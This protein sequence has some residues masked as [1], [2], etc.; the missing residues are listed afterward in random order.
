ELYHLHLKSCIHFSNQLDT[1]LINDN[2]ISSEELEMISLFKDWYDFILLLE[3]LK[4]PYKGKYK[5]PNEMPKE[6]KQLFSSKYMFENI[7]ELRKKDKFL[8]SDIFPF[9]NTFGKLKSSSKMADSF[10]KLL[11]NVLYNGKL[12]ATTK[13]NEIIRRYILEDLNFENAK[14]INLL[15][16]QLPEVIL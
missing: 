13:N 2:F 12:R 9:K 15:H 7:N 11:I 3:K 6:F 10:Y 1:N 16:R 4:Q 8:S 14:L 5:L